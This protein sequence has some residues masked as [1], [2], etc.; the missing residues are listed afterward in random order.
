MRWREGK[1]TSRQQAPFQIAADGLVG[2]QSGLFTPPYEGDWSPPEDALSSRRRV[3]E[4]SLVF[5]NALPGP[6]PVF[7]SQ[8]VALDSVRTQKSLENGIWAAEH[9]EFYV[10]PSSFRFNRTQQPLRKGVWVASYTDNTRYS[11]FAC[12]RDHIHWRENLPSYPST[13]AEILSNFDA[14]V[15]NLG[16]F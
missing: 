4:I 5:I 9:R 3:G 12:I 8:S 13:S 1:R 6:S 15:P 14:I 11:N 16:D 7:P 2:E 10:H